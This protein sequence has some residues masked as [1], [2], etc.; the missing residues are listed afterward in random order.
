[1]DTIKSLVAIMNK[2][3][4]LEK[5]IQEFERSEYKWRTIPKIAKN[6][7]V[8][9]EAVLELLLRS[10]KFIKSKKPNKNGE[11]LFTTVNKYKKETSIFFRALSA[12][13]NTS[14]ID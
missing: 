4:L 2:K 9:N 12:F 5:I 3:E 13:S 1:M 10:D 7:G 8:K 6:L 11:Q 14:G